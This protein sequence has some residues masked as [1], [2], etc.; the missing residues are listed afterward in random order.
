MYLKITVNL[1]VGPKY[2]II[3]NQP[4]V[5]R[6]IGKFYKPDMP[7][8]ICDLIGKLNCYDSD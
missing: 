5:I 3:D 2:S 6:N 4:I 8:S 7:D 1:R